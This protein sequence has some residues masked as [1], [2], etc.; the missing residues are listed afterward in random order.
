M[1]PQP[2]SS[3]KKKTTKDFALDFSLI[4]I[5]K[6]IPNPEKLRSLKVR[7]SGIDQSLIAQDHRQ[8]IL[9]ADPP[10]D[11]FYVTVNV[12]DPEA[13]RREVRSDAGSNDAPPSA[14]DL[15]ETISIQPNHPE[16]V[17]QANQIVGA[18]DAANEK[19][20][21]LVQWTA[22]NISNQMEDTFRPLKSLSVLRAG[23]GE[24]ESHATLYAA[25]ARSQKIPTRLVTGIVYMEGMGFL[26]H[27]WAESCIDGWIAVDPTFNQ[28]PADA[29]H[30]KVATGDSTD[31]AQIVLSM[32]G[33]VKME[34]LEYHY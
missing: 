11:G 22:K 7:M 29:T 17:N 5:P 16:I 18:K 32:T 24:C 25:L 31:N 21:K 23:K 1:K 28:V 13:A 14:E 19:V 34:A 10:A 33:K 27:A 8:K 6:P 9:P 12:E 2:A 3:Q 15:A 20:A 4:R 30:I 26:Y